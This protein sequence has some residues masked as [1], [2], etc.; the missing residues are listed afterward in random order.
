[1]FEWGLSLLAVFITG[2]ITILSPNWFPA[3]TYGHVGVAFNLAFP[4]LLAA[5]PPGERPRETAE[6]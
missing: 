6:T 5:Q 2:H 3:T 4:H 1:M